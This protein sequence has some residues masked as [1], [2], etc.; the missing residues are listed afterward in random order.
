MTNEQVVDTAELEQDEIKETID[1]EVT[2][3]S[4]GEDEKKTSAK[5]DT[6]TF[7]QEELNDTVRKRLERERKKFADYDELKQKAEA[8][9]EAIRKAERDK[10]TEVE[11]LE[12]DLQEKEEELTRYREESEKARREAEELRIRTEFEIKAREAGIKYVEDAYRLADAELLSK[13]EVVNG[14]VQG[15][16]DVIKDIA[17]NKPYLLSPAQPIGKPMAQKELPKKTD[18]EV[19]RAAAEKARR[20]GTAE[21]R[22]EYSRLKRELGLA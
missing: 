7:T 4:G 22:A 8:Y 17:E 14:G 19:L 15:V 2:E 6:V 18:E 13:I 16:D 10:M 1:E 12:A 3:S 21:A 11:R 5:Q 20:E 9:E